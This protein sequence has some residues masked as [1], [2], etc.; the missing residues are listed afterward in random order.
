[1]E[2]KTDNNKLKSRGI[3]FL[4]SRFFAYRIICYFSFLLIP[5]WIQKT[6]DLNQSLQCLMMVLYIG[7]MIGQW[8]LLGKEIDYRLKIYFRVN[9]S[10]DRVVYR[11]FLGMIFI[12]L[13]FNMLSF[14][15]SKW[16][17]NLFWTTWVVLGLFYS[18]P[19]RGK[20]IKE[21]VSTNFAEFRYLDSFEK[22]LLGLIALLFL[23]SV[24]KLPTL[25]NIEALKLYFD[26]AEKFSMQLWNFLIVNYYPFKKYP[27]LFKLAW[28]MHFYFVGMGGFLL[29]FYALLRYFVS[30]RLSLLG[31]F[32][33]LSSWSFSKILALDFGASINTTYSVLWIW[34]LLWATKSSTYRAGLFIGLIGYW[35]AIINQSFAIL[36]IIQIALLY[37]FFLKEKT[38]WFK[39]QILKYVILG[40]VLSILT[41]IFQFESL[42]DLGSIRINFWESVKLIVNRKAFYS[43]S[44]FGVIVLIAKVWHP[45]LKFIK[46]IYLGQEKIIQLFVSLVVILMFSIFFDNYLIKAFAL[47]WP[48]TL[49]SLV[50][51]ELVFQSISRLRSNRNLI[52]LVYIIICLLDSHF[53]GRVKIFLKLFQ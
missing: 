38:F 45:E 23:F 21:S 24:P 30:R 15:P 41:L 44:V 53:E 13:Y 10:I 20:I 35:G 17:Y 32:A 33:L 2:L 49:F 26:S 9:S 34:T 12:V 16:I 52:Y 3:L 6:Q 40:F 5:V 51:L 1:M 14:L 22:T 47:M 28:S 50:P 27:V 19:T 43:L 8:F 31:V 36:L 48:I 4:K 11:M 37:F 7:F 46:M 42:S 18:W 29:V 39:K 25:V